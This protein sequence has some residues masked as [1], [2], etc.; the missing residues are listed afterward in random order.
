MRKLMLIMTMLVAL[1]VISGC[2]KEVPDPNTVPDIN[3]N[4]NTQTN[5]QPEQAQ[6]P[7][8]PAV[9]V[10]SS[11][12]DPIPNIKSAVIDSA[13]NS[14][15]VE[16][17]NNVPNPITLPLTGTWAKYSTTYCKTWEITGVYKRDA[18]VAL[19]TEIQQ[20]DA[21]TVKWDCTEP[22]TAATGKDFSADIAFNY[23]NT[24]TGMI[25]S[26]TGTVSGKYT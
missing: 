5:A 17:R 2:Q 4:A 14:I 13:T 21:F 18:I 7:E 23:K 25:R 22:N 9:P 8:E 10:I 20:G 11:F 16:F 26:Q 6:T 15:T 12:T 1:L 19:Q 24:A 3:D